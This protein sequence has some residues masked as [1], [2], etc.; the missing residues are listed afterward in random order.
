MSRCMLE[1]ALNTRSIGQLQN[2]CKKCEKKHLCLRINNTITAISAINPKVWELEFQIR[3]R[4]LLKELARL[5]FVFPDGLNLC[6]ISHMDRREVVN[7]L[8]E[9]QEL[10]IEMTDMKAQ[11]LQNQESSY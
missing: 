11:Q 4:S 5:G 1:Q 3:F 9:A 7:L 6:E 10:L 2:A 8:R